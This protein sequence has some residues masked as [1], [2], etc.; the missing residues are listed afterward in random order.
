MKQS[1]KAKSVGMT[2]GHYSRQVKR[3]LNK[4]FLTDRDKQVMVLEG[5]EVEVKKKNSK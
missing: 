3:L 5:L 1:E 4:D 2:Q